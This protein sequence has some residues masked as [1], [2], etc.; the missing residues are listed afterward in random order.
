MVIRLITK[1]LYAEIALTNLILNVFI[2]KIQQNKLIDK[3]H[4]VIQLKNM[5]LLL[6]SMN[7]CLKN[8]RVNVQFVLK[9]LKIS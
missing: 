2:L 5:D 1:E 6:K 4:I 3:Q 9:F 7:K 8:K